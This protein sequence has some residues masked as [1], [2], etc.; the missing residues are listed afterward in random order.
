MV[1]QVKYDM[2]VDDKMIQGMNDQVDFLME[3]GRIPRKIEP[4]EYMDVSI[5]Q[6]QFPDLVKWKPA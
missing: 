3:L 6:K 4:K 2:T 1:S 5:L